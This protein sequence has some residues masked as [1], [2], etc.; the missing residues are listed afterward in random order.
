MQEENKEHDVKLQGNQA[1]IRA[2]GPG[3]EPRNAG[4]NQPV[5]TI[6]GGE[7]NMTLYS[8]I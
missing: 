1:K 4:I 8:P 2:S 7:P 6:F 5:L 3:G